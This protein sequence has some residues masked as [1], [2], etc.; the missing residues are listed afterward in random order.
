MRKSVPVL[1]AAL[2]ACLAGCSSPEA[3]TPAPSPSQPFDAK[4]A[5]KDAASCFS[6]GGYRLRGEKGYLEVGTL[7]EADVADGVACLERRL[8]IDGLAF[9]LKRDLSTKRSV[10]DP[11]MYEHYKA[12]GY[13]IGEAPGASIVFSIYEL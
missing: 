1:A 2:V 4:P 11:H 3:V 8:K 5:M 7:L 13:R 12:V 10:S 9:D 6:M